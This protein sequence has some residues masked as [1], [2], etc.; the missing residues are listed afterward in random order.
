MK[1]F[2]TAGSKRHYD[3]NGFL[4]VE[5]CAIL[6]SG[7]FEYLGI[8]ISNDEGII[9]GVKVEPDKLYRVLIPVE[10]LEKA[11]DTFKLLP[12]VNDHTWLGD[13]EEDA[14]EYQEGSTGENIFVQD[15]K[16]IV[17]MKFTGKNIIE[18]IENGKE[19]L[20][21]SYTNIL[22]KSDNPEYDFIAMDYTGNHI[23]LVDK[24]RCGKDVRVSNSDINKLVNQ[25]KNMSKKHKTKNEAILY[26]DGKEIDLSQFFS[27][28]A[29]ETDENSAS[30][31]ND[32]INAITEILKGKVDDDIIKAVIDQLSAKSDNTGDENNNPDKEGIDNEDIEDKPISG[33]EILISADLQTF[34]GT[35]EI[36]ESWILEV[37]HSQGD[38]DISDYE[39]M[40]VNEA[41]DETKGAKVLLNGVVSQ[42]TYNS[43]KVAT[44]F[45]LVDNT[46]SIYVFDMETAMQVEIGNKIQIAGTRDNWILEKEESNAE[47]WGYQGCIQLTETHLI[48]NDNGDNSWDK[49]WVKESSVKKLLE[50]DPA[51][52]NITTEIYKVN[53]LV[54]KQDGS[55]FVNYYFNDLDGTTGS[56][57]YSQANGSDFEWLNEF[58]GKICTVYLM[59]I[60]YKSEASGVIPRLLPIE[61]KDE[62]FEFNPQNGAQF[63][64]DYYVEDLFDVDTYYANPNLEVPTSATNSLIGID[65]AKITYKSSDESVIKFNEVKG[66][67]YMDVLNFDEKDVTITAEATYAGV[68]AKLEKVIHAN[69]YLIDDTGVIAVT[70]DTKTLGQLNV[71][72]EVVLHGTRTQFNKIEEQEKPGQ[73]CILDA[74]IDVNL[75]GN[76]EY[77]TKTFENKTF[78][79]LLKLDYKEDL[80][81]KVYYVKAKVV[82]VETDK[83]TRMDFVDPNDSTKTLKLYSSSA[84]QYKFLFDYADKVL[85]YA[86]APCN[87]NKKNYYAF[88]VL[89]VQLE[90]GTIIN[91]ELNFESN[92]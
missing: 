7:V 20:S 5:D 56:Y 82:V 42:F 13:G 47:K 90:D 23:A 60:N 1:S 65:N 3:D 79:E 91:N 39:A 58:D 31:N 14:K 67:T 21:A 12:I 71:G 80:T 45:I 11:K 24:G 84:N 77:S 9:D 36:H 63:V 64:L 33:D 69:F 62:N 6:K 66:V 54:K 22:K 92:R 78:D 88:C 76:N 26:I 40:S 17:P 57:T 28:K 41:R 49:S 73:S 18:A 27:D 8:E 68:T 59:V 87:W 16:L 46:S 70:T 75:Y 51:K 85:T 55:G 89:N 43:S 15:G 61:V 48:S 81:N 72:D 44:G 4:F 32:V 34:K 50:V 53:A 19:E 30:D 52:E 83:Y 29:S 37:K 86:V 74:V 38:F 35:P 10:E 2:I 25:E